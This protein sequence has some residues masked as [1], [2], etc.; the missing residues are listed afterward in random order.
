MKTLFTVLCA[1]T[2]F[3][4]DWNKPVPPVTLEF[5]GEVQ[6]GEKGAQEFP[7]GGTTVLLSEARN[8]EVQV[9]RCQD[10]LGLPALGFTIA[11]HQN[12]QFGDYSEAL[13]NK[14]LAI[15]KDGEILNLPTVCGRM[16]HGGVIEGGRGGVTS[17]EL[18]NLMAAIRADA[19]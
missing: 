15:L 10:Q 16:D 6:P 3:S 13:M 1:L 2:L 7:Y 18:D 4:C 5:R 19:K 12:E 9:Y 8:F 17:E 11:V 14:R